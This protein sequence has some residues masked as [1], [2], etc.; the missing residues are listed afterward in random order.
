MKN[1]IFILGLIFSIIVGATFSFGI[2]KNPSFNIHD[3]FAG[4]SSEFIGWILAVTL[5][6]YYFDAKMA[7]KKKTTDQNDNT[8][9]VADEILKF[10]SLLDEEI[11][12]AEEFEDSK[13][14]LLAKI[15]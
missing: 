2:F 15:D 5:F 7:A 3:F 11:I 4:L 9:S 12:T 8:L 14:K 13:N 6:Q 10:K 1:K